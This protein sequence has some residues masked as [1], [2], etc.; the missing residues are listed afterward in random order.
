MG[1]EATITFNDVSNAAN[2]ILTGGG[3]PTVRSVREELGKGSQATVHAHF[4]QWQLDQEAHVPVINENLMDP[5]ITRA[6]NL[7]ITT[8][9]KEATADITSKLI[10]EQAN[11]EGVIR[12][13]TLQASA[14]ESTVTALTEVE[15]QY[16]TLTGRAE[17]YE[18]EAKRLNTEL[19]NERKSGEVVRTE[20]A[21]TKTMLDRTDADLKKVRAE[22]EEARAEAAV[23]SEAAAVA[24]ARFDSEI[25]HRNRLKP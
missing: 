1:R 19:E 5:T 16:A 9:I 14:L 11:C 20:L 22:L 17:L 4:K 15:T 25:E 18:S 13:Y 24:K 12:E 3:K 8:R 23:N 21:I 6:I 7:V 10:E 2:K